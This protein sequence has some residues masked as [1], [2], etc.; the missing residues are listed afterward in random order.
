MCAATSE[1]EGLE[2][3]HQLTRA[4]MLLPH[5][6]SVLALVRSSVCK[7]QHELTTSTQG[8]KNKMFSGS[9]T[10]KKN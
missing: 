7:C 5:G 6:C 10:N 3:M 9:S 4:G 1:D 2:R 8:I